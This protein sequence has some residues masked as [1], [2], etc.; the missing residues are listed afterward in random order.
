M[1]QAEPIRM[2]IKINLQRD[3]PVNYGSLHG[4]LRNQ[5]Q[6]KII[7]SLANRRAQLWKADELTS[8]LREGNLDE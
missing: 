1:A 6:I 4:S 2:E 5:A 7:A 8:S 3:I